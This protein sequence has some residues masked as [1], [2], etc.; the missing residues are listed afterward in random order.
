MVSLLGGERERRA[1][2]A[3]PCTNRSIKLVRWLYGGG[4]DRRNNE[5]KVNRSVEKDED[6]TQ[7]KKFK[8][9]VMVRDTMIDDPSF[10]RKT[11]LHTV[12]SLYSVAIP[13]WIS[14]PLHTALALRTAIHDH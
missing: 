1:A 4:D 10:T 6:D 11:L 3:R 5:R 9:A 13:L 12:Y 8:P 7:R 14:V 2:R